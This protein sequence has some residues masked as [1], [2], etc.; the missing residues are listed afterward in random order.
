MDRKYKV[1]L[2]DDDETLLLGMSLILMQADYEVVTA[3]GGLAGLDAA[4]TDRPDLIVC[5]VMMPKLN[6]FEVRERLSGD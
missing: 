6:G 5:D 1:L 3:A 2:I 4:Q